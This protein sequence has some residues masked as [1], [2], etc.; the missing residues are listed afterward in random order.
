MENKIYPKTK[1]MTFVNKNATRNSE[2]FFF[3]KKGDEMK[4]RFDERLMRG[5]S[6]LWSGI[7]RPSFP[8]NVFER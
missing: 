5:S 8:R 1:V 3:F 2:Y 7:L 6:S 4:K